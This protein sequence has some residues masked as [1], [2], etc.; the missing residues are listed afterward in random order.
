MATSAVKKWDARFAHDHPHNTNYYLTCCIGGVFSCGLTHLA[1]TPLDVAKC[2]MQ[3]DP[4][5][6]KGLSG[7]FSTIMK[8]EGKY[9]FNPIVYIYYIPLLNIIIKIYIYNDNNNLL[10]IF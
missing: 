2:N 4:T 9:N 8:E 10:F 1:V 5:K 6:Y 7:A 3:V